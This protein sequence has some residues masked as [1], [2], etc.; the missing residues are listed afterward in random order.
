MTLKIGALSKL[1]L[2]FPVVCFSYVFDQT[3]AGQLYRD[4]GLFWACDYLFTTLRA[5]LLSTL[6]VHKIIKLFVN[7]EEI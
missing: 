2:F 6:V 5:K 4:K 3:L 7:Y 1:G